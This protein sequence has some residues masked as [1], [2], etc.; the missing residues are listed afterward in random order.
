MSCSA[1]T[2]MSARH[3]YGVGGP[4]AWPLPCFLHSSAYFMPCFLSSSATA[5]SASMWKTSAITA[6]CQS[7]SWR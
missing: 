5:P 6:S 7:T 4:M 1:S 3:K 2:A